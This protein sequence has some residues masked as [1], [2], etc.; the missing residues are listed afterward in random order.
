MP[1]TRTAIMFETAILRYDR[2]SRVAAIDIGRRPPNGPDYA[3]REV[4]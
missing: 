2:L 1:E 3:V 4:L